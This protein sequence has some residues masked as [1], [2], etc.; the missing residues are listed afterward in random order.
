MADDELMQKT[1][2]QSAAPA[3]PVPDLATVATPTPARAAQAPAGATLDAPLGTAPTP[4]RRVETPDRVEAE[5]GPPMRTIHHVETSY[6]DRWVADPDLGMVKRHEMILGRSTTGAIA[7]KGKTYNVTD[8]GTFEV[9]ED[10]AA[11]LLNQKGWHEGAT[12]FPPDEAAPSR[13]SVVNPSPSPTV[14]TLKSS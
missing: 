14:S 10:L 4:A 7:H 12:P 5:P 6:K 8:D 2:I 13:A 11:F 1:V 3:K 9:P